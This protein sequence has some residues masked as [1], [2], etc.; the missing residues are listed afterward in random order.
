MPVVQLHKKMYERKVPTG[1]I[2]K[3]ENLMT[4]IDA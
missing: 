2:K 4:I 3:T 1:N